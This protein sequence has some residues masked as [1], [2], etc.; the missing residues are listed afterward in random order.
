MT[1]VSIDDSSASRKRAVALHQAGEIQRAA[2]MYEALLQ[3][4]T[5]R[6]DILGLLSVAQLQLGKR[7]EA[8]VSWRNSLLAEKAI[9]R[10]LR[11]IANFL[12]AMLQL[13]EAQS[14]Q[15]KNETPNTDFLDGV[16]IP[17]WPKDLPIERDDQAII[18]ALAGCLV[19]LDRN[20]AGLRLLDSG[21]AQLS[22]DPDFVAAAVSIM[23]DAGSAGK[24]LSLLRPLTSAAHQDNA[25]LFIA[26]AAAALASGRKEEARALSL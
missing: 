19:K 10:R 15:R 9:P 8:L 26:H 13:D 1:N 4:G 5:A 12:L 20:E 11:N 7:K 21:F 23:L 24:A 14:L 17:V 3:V 16:D 2:D 6:A 25:A 18:L 22:G